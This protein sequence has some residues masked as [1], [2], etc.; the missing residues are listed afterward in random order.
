[1]HPDSCGPNKTLSDKIKK[2]REILR[3][4]QILGVDSWWIEQ[5]FDST[6]LPS[7]LSPRLYMHLDGY[8]DEFIGQSI[9]ALI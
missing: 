2:F 8:A 5:Q 1:M 3:K 4:L 7:S 9:K 6:L